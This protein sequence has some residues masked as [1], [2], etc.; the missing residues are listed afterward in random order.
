MAKGRLKDYMLT[1]DEKKLVQ[2]VFDEILM[3]PNVHEILGSIT[4]DRMW[5]LKAKLK[6]E[7]YCKFHN[8]KYEDMTEEQLEEASMQSYYEKYE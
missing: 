7:D 1:K 5:D 6:F 3:L 4:I 2:S 8:V